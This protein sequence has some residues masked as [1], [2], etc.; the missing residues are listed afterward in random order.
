VTL[1]FRRISPEAIPPV[2]AHDG[3]AG[4][5]LHAVESVTIEPGDRASVGTGIALAIPEGHAGL[6]VPRSGLAARHGIALVNAPGLIDAGYRGELRVLLWNGDRREPF[7]V[8]P[9]DRIAQLVIVRV[10]GP[11][12]EEVGELDETARGEGGFGS[13][14][15]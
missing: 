8:E 4:F 7:A 14:G 1:R 13:T 11:A 3:D 12:L 15:R 10:E 9:G 5:D 2:R 6:V